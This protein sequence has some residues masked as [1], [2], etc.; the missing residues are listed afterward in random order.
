MDL[1]KKLESKVNDTIHWLSSPR[2][3]KALYDYNYDVDTDKY[4]LRLIVI[5]RGR[6]IKIPCTN[7][8][9][10]IEAAKEYSIDQI[11]GAQE[12]VGWDKWTDLEFDDEG[13]TI[14]EIMERMEVKA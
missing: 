3:I 7:K 13:N 12:Y 9:D 14:F 1:I 4:P 5:E 2:R 6:K 10:L 11:E 8:A